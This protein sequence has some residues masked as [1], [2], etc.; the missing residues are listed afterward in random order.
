M[1]TFY[2]LILIAALSTFLAGCSSFPAGSAALLAAPGA[3]PCILAIGHDPV[4][5]IENKRKGVILVKTFADSRRQK[6]KRAI[7][8]I[9]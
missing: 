2:S 6:A 3:G 8:S 4:G 9:P 5:L 7:G 1:K